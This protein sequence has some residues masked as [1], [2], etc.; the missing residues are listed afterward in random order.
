MKISR[1]ALALTLGWFLAGCPDKPPDP[2]S[3]RGDSLPTPIKQKPS[4]VQYYVPGCDACEKIRPLLDDLEKTFG[5]DV[6]FQ[7]RDATD[8]K[9][10]KAVQRA[11]AKDG[12]RIAIVGHDGFPRFV[13]GADHEGNRDLLEATIRETLDRPPG[14]KAEE[15]R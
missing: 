4:V 7:R 14:E 13:E 8:E 2:S 1:V 6:S 5:D 10:E 15:G 11:G 9:Y 3:A 12:H